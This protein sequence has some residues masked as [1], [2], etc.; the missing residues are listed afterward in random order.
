MEGPRYRVKMSS[1]TIAY[2]TADAPWSVHTLTAFIIKLLHC[3][4]ASKAPG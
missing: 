1:L 4:H 3:R 2:R